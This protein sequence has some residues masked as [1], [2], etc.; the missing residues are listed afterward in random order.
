M[1][2][3]PARH[4]GS[5]ARSRPEA[6]R[7]PGLALVLPGQFGGLHTDLPLIRAA[8][9]DHPAGQPRPRVPVRVLLLSGQRVPDLNPGV[10]RKAPAHPGRPASFP[11]RAIRVTEVRDRPNDRS[12][13]PY[14]RPPRRP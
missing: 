4:P 6:H 5:G 7:V 2:R 9:A 10:L 14:T 11:P 3:P 12:P 13:P 8:D 1:I